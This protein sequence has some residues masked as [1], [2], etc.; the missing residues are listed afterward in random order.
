MFKCL[1]TGYK[2]YIGNHIYNELCDRN[3]TVKGIDLKDGT[4]ILEYLP[5]ENFDYVFHLAA[6]PRVGFSVENPFYTL[7]QNCYYK[8]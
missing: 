6:I 8:Y 3:Y 5:N 7:E 2:G 1:V 4:D